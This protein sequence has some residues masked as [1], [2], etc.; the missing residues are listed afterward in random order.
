MASLKS[1]AR[2]GDHLSWDKLPERR[3]AESR[4]ARKPRILLAASGSVAALKF[5]ILAD[6]L[7]DWAEVRAVATKPALHFIDKRGLPASVK[8]YT[9]DD[10]WSSWSRIGDNVLHI[11]LRKWADA[12]LIAP[13][14]ANTLAKVKLNP[15]GFM[16]AVILSRLASNPSLDSVCICSLCGNQFWWVVTS[17]GKAYLFYG[18]S[19]SL[20]W[21][22]QIINWKVLNQVVYVL[23]KILE[24]GWYQLSL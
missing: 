12:M 8:L 11:E 20:Q 24:E 22:N 1:D 2:S 10:E 3:V 14:S 18:R 5:G 15:S 23:S 17:W 19:C 4:G 9:D 6:S 16:D 13:L 21:V 7:S